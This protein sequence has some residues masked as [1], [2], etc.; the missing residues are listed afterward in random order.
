M[1]N[2]PIPTLVADDRKRTD[3]KVS[4]RI[5][6][7]YQ[8]GRQKETIYI[9]LKLYYTKEEWTI[10]N[11]GCDQRGKKSVIYG[12]RLINERAKIAFAKKRIN[13][14]IQSF[15]DKQ[16]P[17][18]VYDVK[19][20]FETRSIDSIS[21]IY[22]MN[23]FDE[24]IDLKG[25]ALKAYSTIESY[26][27]AKKS[28]EKYITNY[29]KA[30]AEKFRITSIDASWIEDYK[31]KMGDSIRETTKN[32]YIISLR[33]VFNYAINQKIIDQ[34]RYPFDAENIDN[35]YNIQTSPKTKRALTPD[36]FDKL[37]AVRKKLSHAQQEAWDYFMLSYLFNGANLRDIAELKYSDIDLHDNTITFKRKKTS[38]KKKND[39]PIIIAFSPQ[40]QKIIELR[41]NKKDSEADQYIFPIFAGTEKTEI[42]KTEVVKYK[43]HI[44]G[45][46]WDI[47]A[48][49][50]GIRK[51]L[52]YQMARHTFATTAIINTVPIEEIS[53]AMGHSSV[54][55]TKDYI[56]TL[57]KN[58][59][60]HNEIVKQENIPLEIF[61]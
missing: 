12:D 37:K 60:P 5:R 23:L 34:S 36:E 41:G 11:D 38:R 61:N 30:K 55:Q 6:L 7:F 35:Y 9:T 42:E 50:A 21:R 56:S 24:I 26:R 15:E 1:I 17:Y 18:S 49:K 27:Y 46:K 19:N 29:L 53:K 39:D 33:A 25:R 59:T 13:D 16:M 48:K 2:K 57:P 28:F 45:K 31:Q 3:D 22:L 10:I 51:D 44:W 52:T 14:I 4:I 8:N 40:I 20:E 47:I 43:T 32:D 54:G 58:L